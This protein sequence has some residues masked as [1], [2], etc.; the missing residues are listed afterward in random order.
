YKKDK[1]NIIVVV[2]TKDILCALDTEIMKQDLRPI[3][4][5]SYPDLLIDVLNKF[6]QGRQHFALV[7]KKNQLIGFITLDNLLTKLNGRIY[8]ELHL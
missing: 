5:V 8:D 6:Q 3:L 1:N 7:Y 4:K 2:L